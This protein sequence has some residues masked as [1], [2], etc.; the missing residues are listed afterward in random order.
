MSFMTNRTWH[1]ILKART[2][3]Q[4]N[5]VKLLLTPDVSKYC[6]FNIILYVACSIVTRGPA[7]N[8]RIQT[9]INF[10]FLYQ[11]IL[12]T[13]PGFGIC[14]C[15]GGHIK[16]S[17]VLRLISLVGSAI[18]SDTDSE[19]SG[20]RE[21]T[22]AIIHAHTNCASYYFPRSSLTSSFRRTSL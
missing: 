10:G 3:F 19:G 20:N 6:T 15:F 22:G 16:P 21:Y 12:N 18:T 5:A 1:W 13:N 4:W 8:P 17:S 7:F 9:K 14:H 11:E 2:Q